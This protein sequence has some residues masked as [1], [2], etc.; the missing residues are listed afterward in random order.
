MQAASRLHANV[1]HSSTKNNLSRMTW[2][3]PL[4]KGKMMSKSTWSPNDQTP[5]ISLHILDLIFSCFLSY[6]SIETSWYSPT[7]HWLPIAFAGIMTIRRCKPVIVVRNFDIWNST[8]SVIKQRYN[9][10]WSSWSDANDRWLI[11]VY[12][13]N[14]RRPVSSG[15][16][17]LK[18]RKD[19]RKQPL[20]EATT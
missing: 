12:N 3:T 7:R 17:C 11:S 16:V 19:F 10:F 15:E 2:I 9:G 20:V 14:N 4:K 8:P 18:R 13:N 5:W 1:F 6:H